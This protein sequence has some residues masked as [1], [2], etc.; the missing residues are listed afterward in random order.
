MVEACV[1]APQVIHN[2][3]LSPFG[4]INLLED[5]IRRILSW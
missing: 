3:R 5:N 2:L 4:L 1:E